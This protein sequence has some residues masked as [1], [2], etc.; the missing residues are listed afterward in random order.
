MGRNAGI[1]AF[2]LTAGAPRM[3]V[4]AC[5]RGLSYLRNVPDVKTS[6]PRSF[7]VGQSFDVNKLINYSWVNHEVGANVLVHFIIFL[8][9]IFLQLPKI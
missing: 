4:S 3:G 8:A 7:N 5:L 1:D 6:A 2:I 9:S